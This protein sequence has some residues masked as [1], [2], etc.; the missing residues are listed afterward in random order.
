MTLLKQVQDNLWLLGACRD[1]RTVR[2]MKGT[3]SRTGEQV[4][5]LHLR[6]LDHPVL[7]RPGTTDISVAWELFQQ[8]EYACTR[9][10]DFATVVDC[11]ANVG[12][13]MA[14]VVMKMNGRL[15]R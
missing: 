8:E 11:G 5:P 2:A 14:Y 10:W 9:P 7:Y 6:A 4:R 15:S 3:A 12:M 1:W 13:F